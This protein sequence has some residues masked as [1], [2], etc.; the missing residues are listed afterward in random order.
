MGSN[1]DSMPK[2]TKECMVLKSPPPKHKLITRMLWRGGWQPKTWEE[3]VVTSEVMSVG[4][5]L[6]TLR[7]W[8][9]GV[10]HSHL[11]NLTCTE[12]LKSPSCQKVKGIRGLEE[13]SG[14]RYMLSCL[15]VCLFVF[16]QRVRSKWREGN[17]VAFSNLN[18]LHLVSAF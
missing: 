2:G 11:S 7:V 4:D 16:S 8:L 1:S 10:T 15:L 13:W 12:C 18:F 17:R 3:M 14:K 6:R 9:A 5:W